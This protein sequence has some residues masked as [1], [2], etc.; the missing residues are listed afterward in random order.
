MPYLMMLAAAWPDGQLGI[1][2]T[3]SAPAAMPQEAGQREQRR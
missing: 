2:I 3:R 1:A